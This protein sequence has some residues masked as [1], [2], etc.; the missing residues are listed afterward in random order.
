LAGNV[1]RLVCIVVASEAFGR[2]AGEFVHNWFGFVT[3]AMA[4]GV[5]FGL[6][7]WLRDDPLPEVAAVAQPKTP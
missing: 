7:H 3:F 2:A 4:L 5:M 6:G 1:A